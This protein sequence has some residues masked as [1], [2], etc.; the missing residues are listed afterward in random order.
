MNDWPGLGLC[1]A[2]IGLSQWGAQLGPPKMLAI[3]ILQLLIR[4]N[5]C[6]SFL[7]LGQIKS[8]FVDRS[9]G[10]KIF[11]I[12]DAQPGA[13]TTPYFRTWLL[14]WACADTDFAS[15]TAPVSI[16]SQCSII[17]SISTVTCAANSAL[18][19]PAIHSMSIFVILLL[20]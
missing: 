12:A 9:Q 15:N 10:D 16:P 19:S 2:E 17:M 7:Y 18:I 1:I 3:D 11:I 6:P 14:A 8:F 4:S 20:T 13:P 5:P